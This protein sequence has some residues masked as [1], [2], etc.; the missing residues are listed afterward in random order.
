M[1][2]KLEPVYGLALFIVSKAIELMQDGRYIEAIDLIKD[3]IYDS[4]IY[5]LAFLAYAYLQ[6]ALNNQENKQE[7][8]LSALQ[9][10]DKAKNIYADLKLDNYIKIQYA[11][12]SM[13]YAQFVDGIVKLKIW[14]DK[15]NALRQYNRLLNNDSKLAKDFY[16]IINE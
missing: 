4:N 16:R 3:N 14:G 5:Q 13:A 7:N 15:E 6:L 11:K 10:A 8:Y 2:N 1:Q 9:Y 12:K